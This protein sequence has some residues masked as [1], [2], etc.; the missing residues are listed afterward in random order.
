MS[1]SPFGRGRLDPVGNRREIE[2]ES[3]GEVGEN[4]G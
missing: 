1:A 4:Y 3:D 2:D